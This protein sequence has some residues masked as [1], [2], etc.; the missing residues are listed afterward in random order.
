MFRE[1]PTPRSQP[2]RGLLDFRQQ[3]AQKKIAKVPK[4]PEPKR[5]ALQV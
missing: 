2:V 3:Q 4:K 5:P 1:K